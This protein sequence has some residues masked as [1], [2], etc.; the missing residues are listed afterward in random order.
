VANQIRL[1]SVN[2]GAGGVQGVWLRHDIE[3]RHERLLRLEQQAREKTIVPSRKRFRLLERYR[4]D[5]RSRHLEASRPASCSTRTRVTGER[6]KGLG[7]VY[8]Q[9]LVDVS[10]SFSFAKVYTSKNANHR[11]RPSQ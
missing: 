7:K 10:W 9:V 1:D 4:S 5:F 3:T 2:V 11:S 8:V 6:S